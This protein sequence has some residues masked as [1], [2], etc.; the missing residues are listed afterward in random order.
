MLHAQG[1]PVATIARQ[2]GVSRPTVYAYLRREAPPGPKRPQFQWSTHV[3]TPS[4]P[5][6][7]RRWRESGAH[8]AQLWPE[9]QALG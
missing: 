8:R 9:I 7:I 5:S 3:L 1:I 2:L 4:I 6:L